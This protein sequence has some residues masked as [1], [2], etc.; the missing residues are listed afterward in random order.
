MISRFAA[1]LIM[2]AATCLMGLVISVGA[3][4]FGIGWGDAGPEPGAF[5]FYIGVMIMVASLGTAVQTLLRRPQGEAFLD[6]ERAGRVAAFFGPML[7][8]VVASLFLGLYVAM[9]AYLFAVM[10]LQG[11]YSSPTSAAAGVGAAI[12]FYV[13]LEIGFKVSLMKGPLEA[14]LGL[15]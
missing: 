7:A 15:Y 11:G 13:L 3:L 8:F 4:E 5:P 6:W 10:R 9:A 1:E 14:A 2:A 12:F